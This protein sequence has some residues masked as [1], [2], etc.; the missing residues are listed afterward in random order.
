MKERWDIDRY[1]QEC[2]RFQWRAIA[3]AVG[4]VLFMFACFALMIPFRDQVKYYVSAWYGAP[5]AEI[6]IGLTPFP[7]V[8]VLFASLF[9]LQRKSNKTPELNCAGCKKFVGG[10]R[11][12]VVATK[13]C[14]H[15]G[16]KILDDVD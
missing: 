6:V 8:I 11:H 16:K 12:L 9:W 13:C 4:T 5:T 10:M 15:C 3:I 14:P 2:N 1:V 7:S